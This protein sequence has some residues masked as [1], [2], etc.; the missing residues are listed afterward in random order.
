VT[1]PASESCKNIVVDAF[2]VLAEQSIE[3]VDVF[4]HQGAEYERPPKR[5]H[6]VVSTGHRAY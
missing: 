4:E 2:D 6:A 5:Y 1:R 3:I